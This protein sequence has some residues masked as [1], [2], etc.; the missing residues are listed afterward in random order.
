MLSQ[1]LKFKFFIEL[2]NEKLENEKKNIDKSQEKYKDELND[3]LDKKKEMSSKIKIQDEK[4]KRLIG[5][6]KFE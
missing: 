1:N 2:L 5:E 3:K 6:L 4:I